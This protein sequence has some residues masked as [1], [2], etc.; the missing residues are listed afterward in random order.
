MP[1]A[2]ATAAIFRSPRDGARRRIDDHSALLAYALAILLGLGLTL[3]VFPAG[4]LFPTGG[5]SG[6]FTAD[7]AQHVIGQ[8]YFIADAWRWPLLSTPNLNA[9]EGINIGLTDSIPIMAVVLKLLAPV[10]PPNFQGISLWYGLCWLLQPIAAVWCVRASGETRLT[11]ALCLAIICVSMPAWWGRFDHAALTSHFLLLLGLGTYSILV[12][13]GS[14]SR[15]AAATGLLCLTVTVHPYLFAMNAALILAAPVTLLL[16]R[17]HAWPASLGY[18]TCA[19]AT[20]VAATWALGYLGTVGEGGYGRFAMNLLSPVWPAGSWWFGRTLP[21][22]HAT[23]VS[24]WEGYNY[25]G[26]GLLAGLLIMLSMP[27]MALAASRRHAGLLLALLGLTMLAL[28]QRVGIGSSLVVTLYRA[29]AFLEQFRSSGRFFWPVS[30][31]LALSIVLM[32]ARMERPRLGLA[33]LMLVAGLQFTDA[34]AMRNGLAAQLRL[35]PRP[36]TVDADGLRPIMA[37]H[38]R[39]VLLPRWT[40]IPTDDLAAGRTAELE[41]LTLASETTL[42]ANTMY[43]AHWQPGTACDDVATASTPLRPGELRIL[44]PSVQ[45]ALLPLVPHGSEICRKIATLAVCTV[46]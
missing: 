23:D 40:C 46:D 25:L 13:H 15:W 1:A 17:D 2:S 28:S 5:D 11:P 43:L 22:I 33:L 42:P 35:P 41:V 34:T 27:S 44:I 32:T 14:L 9:P 16:R 30:Y 18:A 38:Q 7:F 39:L 37:T 29:P 24:G 19:L 8:R 36:W 4:F 45:E 20:A 3:C 21:K 6:P 10:L 26:F 12:R 31:A